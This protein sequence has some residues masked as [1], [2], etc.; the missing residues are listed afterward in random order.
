MSVPKS[1]VRINKKGV[2]YTSLPRNKKRPYSEVPNTAL[3]F[4]IRDQ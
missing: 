1:V 2:Q 4:R 3:L